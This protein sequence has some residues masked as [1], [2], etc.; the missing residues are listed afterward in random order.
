MSLRYRAVTI[1]HGAE[2]SNIS[3][4]IMLMDTHMFMMNRSISSIQA[5]LA[6]N[7]GHMKQDMSLI[8]DDV[9]SMTG[10]IRL[11]SSSVHSPIVKWLSAAVEGFLEFFIPPVDIRD[12]VHP[13]IVITPGSLITQVNI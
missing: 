13:V 7:L 12:K 2:M 9:D 10:G 6:D 11:M 8:T 5:H 4:R 1:R 3:N